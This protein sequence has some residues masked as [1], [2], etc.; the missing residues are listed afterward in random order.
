MRREILLS[1]AVSVVACACGRAAELSQDRQVEILQS[2]LTAFDRGVGL[3]RQD[4]AGAADAFRE[5]AGGFEALIDAGIVNASIEYNLGNTY[6]RLGEL[7]KAIVHYRRAERLAPSHAQVAANL[8]YARDRVEP[9]IREGGKQQLAERLLF[10]NR[11]TTVRQ[12]FWLAAVGSVF[13]WGMLIVWLRLRNNGVFAAAAIGIVLGLANVASIAWEQHEHVT[14]PAAVVVGK[15]IV[16]R[17]GRGESYDAALNAPLGPGVE[18]R[19]LNSSGDWA[20]VQLVDGQTGW[21]PLTNVE[22]I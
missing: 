2:A 16:L 19:I 3:V 11:S 20:E 22:R 18:V 12:R 15:P 6:F 8:K 4:A 14:H 13:G 17:L 5:A 7:G 9:L 21:L 10:W 1:F